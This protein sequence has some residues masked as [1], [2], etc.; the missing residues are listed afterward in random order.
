MLID[1][2]SVAKALEDLDASFFYDKKNEIIFLT[3]KKLFN[4]NQVIDSLSLSEALKKKKNL[5]KVG[6]AYYITGL[7][8]D[9]PSTGNVEYYAKLVK[10]KAILRTLIG[11]AKE[12]SNE[13]YSSEMDSA[14]ILDK[15]EQKIFN[16][17]QRTEANKFLNVK[18]LLGEVLDNWSERKSGML[19]GIPSGFRDIDS[20]LSGFQNSDFIVLAGRPSMGKTALALSFA[21]N[22]AVEYGHKVGIFSLEMSHQQLAERLITSEAEVDSHLVRTGRLP[23]SEWKNLA[24]AAGTLANGEIYIDD[25]AYL[26]ITDLRAKSRR[27]KSE[28]DIEI[29]F[30]DYMQLLHQG[31]R[32]EN[33]LQEISFISRSLKA[34][35]KELNIP[36]V[37]LSQLSRAVE[38]RPNHRPIMSDLRESGAIEQDADVVM[39]IYRKFVYSNDEE[40]K[41][42]AEVIIAKHRNGPTGTSSIAFTDTYAKFENIDYSKQK[43]PFPA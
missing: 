37:G 41:G 3:M 30:V 39:F 4:A 10:D 27:L 42:S 2:E 31:G 13:A 33:R 18:D 14:E 17:S 8:N 15:A 12:M 36:I 29:I 34:M 11:V 43:E 5:K 19:M 26:N 40:D 1:K 22:A 28:K 9:A 20:K 25:S 6:G 21:R 32:V 23:K 16:I 35:A 38:S 24:K 7:A